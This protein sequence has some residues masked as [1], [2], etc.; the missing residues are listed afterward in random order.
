MKYYRRL[1]NEHAYLVEAGNK[2]CRKGN[3]ARALRSLIA[4]LKVI[5]E[6]EET[7]DD[8]S[9]KA[10]CKWDEYL[11]AL[12]GWIAAMPRLSHF[13]GLGKRK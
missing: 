10:A 11:T 1:K 8:W 3:R 2:D 9:E 5:R 6:V 12:E 13:V 4:L 7:T